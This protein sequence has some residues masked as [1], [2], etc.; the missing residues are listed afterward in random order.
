[1][2][3]AIFTVM[4]KEVWK[5]CPSTTNAVE[6]RNKD[7]KSDTP[8][9]LK[10]AMMKVYKVD[11]VACLK[12]ITA[13]SGVSLT[14][15]STTEEARRRDALRKQKQRMKSIPDKTS[16]HG[17]PDRPSNFSTPISS[18]KR[19]RGS[20]ETEE[21]LLAGKKKALSSPENQ[22]TTDSYS[23]VIGKNIRM[24]FETS[25]ETEVWYNGIICSYNIITKKYGVYFPCDQQTVETSLDDSD[26][27][28]DI[29]D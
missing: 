16:Q 19:G 12:H 26:V 10:L 20:T 8:G 24:K 13:E 28:M 11:E 22:F 7:C 3:S 2:L 9:S 25:S 21:G 4:D 23:E 15:R 18:R 14:Y 29:N 1:M 6:R 27:E 5:S 17:P